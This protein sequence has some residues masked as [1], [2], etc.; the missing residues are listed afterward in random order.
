[1]VKPWWNEPWWIGR[2]WDFYP[3]YSYLF[4]HFYFQVPTVRM[5]YLSMSP[6][7]R[8]WKR[9]DTFDAN[10]VECCVMPQQLQVTYPKVLSRHQSVETFCNSSDYTDD[11]IA[12]ALLPRRP[13]MPQN[14]VPLPPFSFASNFYYIKI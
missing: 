1:M 3:F 12:M 5:S 14:L 8:W 9:V 4:Y 6:T 7:F 10:V 2:S 11:G 13:L